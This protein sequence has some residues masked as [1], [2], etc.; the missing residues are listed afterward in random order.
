MIILQYGLNTMVRNVTDYSYFTKHLV[1]VVNHLRTAFPNTDILIMGISD[2]CQNVGG[3]KQT[4]K[5][6]Y[7]LSQA[8]R[9]AAI[10][11]G[12]HFWDCCEAMKTLGGMATFVDNRWA[13]K[14]YTHIN[15]AGGARV[16]EEFIKAMKYA[17]EKRVATA[18][19]TETKTESETQ[20]DTQT[21]TEIN[22]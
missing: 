3:T 11:A 5:A 16:A 6:V 8:Q 13:N 19:Q 20:A 17:L 1:N 4:M 2:R 12:C 22:E 18:A 9:D 21:V 7:A 10:E 14:D 15:R